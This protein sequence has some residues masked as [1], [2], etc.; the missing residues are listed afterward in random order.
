MKLKNVE[1]RNSVPKQ[2]IPEILKKS[3]AFII[4]LEDTP[5]YK[6]GI[7]LNK[8]HDYLASGKPGI[9]SGNSINNPVEKANAGFTVPPKDPQAIAKGILDLYKLSDL[10][11]EK[12]SCGS[13]Y[14]K[15]SK[16]NHIS[17]NKHFN[18]MFEQSKK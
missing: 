6:Y 3:K 5:L 10:E 12:C 11:R 18:Y 8:I 4:C 13:E 14:F 17:T 2:R 7:S 15:K 16:R 1:F 9:F